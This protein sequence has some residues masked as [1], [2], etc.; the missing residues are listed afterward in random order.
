MRG[1]EI[2]PATN[3]LTRKNHTPNNIVVG[4]DRAQVRFLGQFFETKPTAVD[5]ITDD[6]LLGH[7]GLLL[8][9][10]GHH[11]IDLSPEVRAKT[12]IWSADPITKGSA[13]A[14]TLVKFANSLLENGALKRDM[15]DRA[16]DLL[17]KKNTQDIVGMLWDAVWMLSA[18]LPEFRHWK[19]PWETPVRWLEPDVDP[20]LRLNVLYTDLV[21]F[22]YVKCN[23]LDG[24]KKF[25]IR[26]SKIARYKQW[27]L[28]L[29]R[30]YATIRELSRWRSSKTSPY[31]CAM[32]ISAIWP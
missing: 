22:A 15:T 19:Q 23:E 21:G 12:G 2:P 32:K 6:S 1:T 11:Q 4:A 27:N 5:R 26:P 9:V 16:A 18:P 17:V 20:R 10:L 30:V 24:A 3:V 31:L 14:N 7:A 28:D 8:H 25:G 29:T 13:A